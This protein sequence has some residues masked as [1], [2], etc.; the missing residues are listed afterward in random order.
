MA[1]LPIFLHTLPLV[2]SLLVF[3]LAEMHVLIY[4]S[5]DG[6]LEIFLSPLGLLTHLI[7]ALSLMLM[8]LT[9]L[10]IYHSNHAYVP[11]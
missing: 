4:P 6:L 8:L 5:M 10:L 9:E 1:S 2:I 3:F 11:S 7:Y